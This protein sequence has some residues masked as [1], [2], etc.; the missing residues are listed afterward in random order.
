MSMTMKLVNLT[1][2]AIHFRTNAHT[3][4][5]LTLPPT[6]TPARVAVERVPVMELE[7]DGVRIPVNGTKMG[8]VENLPPPQPGVYYVV[9]RVVA[10]AARARTDL[11]IVDD[12]VRDEQG[13]IVGARALARV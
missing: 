4:P 10:E 7:V 6:A 2:H 13:R 11:L 5:Y 12:T 9:S 8:D 3:A 1:P